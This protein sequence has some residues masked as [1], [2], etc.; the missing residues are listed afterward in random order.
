VISGYTLTKDVYVHLM[1]NK[2]SYSFIMIDN[3]YYTIYVTIRKYYN[4]R[5]I[6]S[7]PDPGL[8]RAGSLLTFASV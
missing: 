3:A 2:V 6:T 5:G 7:S 1:L 8:A 4:L